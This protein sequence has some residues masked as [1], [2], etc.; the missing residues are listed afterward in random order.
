MVI[1]LVTRAA[2]RTPARVFG[3]LCKVRDVLWSGSG[4]K[5]GHT[6]A[7]TTVSEVAPSTAG[8]CPPG[9]LEGQ[10]S[11]VA[12][13]PDILGFLAD[14]SGGASDVEKSVTR[15]AVLS[16][17]V[18]EAVG[19]ATTS[20]TETAGAANI[21]SASATQISATF[22]ELSETFGS[23]TVAAKVTCEEV[24]QS[25]IVFDG[26]KTSAATVGDVLGLIDEITM[27][28]N[29][30]SINALIEAAHAGD[31]GRGFAIVAAEV[32]RLAADTKSA[33]GNIRGLMVALL[34]EID[35]CVVQMST[36]SERS[37]SMLV[38]ARSAGDRLEKDCAT[39]DR[40]VTAIRDAASMTERTASEV[41]AAGNLSM[42]VG[43]LAEEVLST[44]SVQTFRIDEAI[45]AFQP[46]RMANGS[47]GIS[48]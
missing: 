10:E 11:P 17:E 18:G 37:E 44:T 19:A 4:R 35:A 16:A 15:M 26:L 29:M 24:A 46:S 14:V 30:L 45:K 21:A 43:M 3:S 48:G 28:S 6:L 23:V 40:V 34:K 2:R 39:A 32:K 27:K 20:A 13:Q 5:S 38:H 12:A 22:A 47:R 25:V 7:L 36:L 41:T 9:A 1:A 8:N 42:T 33:T 31:A